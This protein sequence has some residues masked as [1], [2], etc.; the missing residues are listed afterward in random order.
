MDYK[1][2]IKY[3][4]DNLPM[5][6]RVGP[7]ALKN[8]LDNTLAL[9]KS[10]GF[11]HSQY[12][13]IHVA[14]T[15]GKGSVSHLLAA[16]LQSA[17]YKT[18]LF[19]S[20]HLKNFR[21]RIRVNGEM[22]PEEDVVKFVEEF[23]GKNRTLNLQTSFFELTA[24]MAFDYF[25]TRKVDVAVIE[26][27]LGGRL[28]STNIISPVLSIITNI[29]FD[30]TAIL[31][32]TLEKIAI[33]KAGIIKDNIPVIIGETQA[34]TAA[35]FTEKAREKNSPILFADKIYKI[36]QQAHGT[37]FS[38]SS[39]DTE[40]V[41]V[42]LGLKGIYQQK[43]L[44]TVL[45]SVDIL[46]KIGF[47]IDKQEVNFGLKNVVSLTGLQG[48]WQ[49]LGENP[50]IISDTGHNEAGIRLVVDQLLK[51]PFDRLHI[52][53]GMVNDKDVNTILSLLP[54]NAE[55]YFTKASIERALDEN[56]L[57]TKATSYGLRGNAYPSV[58][59]AL[60]A[61]KLNAGKNDLIFVGGSTFVVAEVV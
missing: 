35:I 38:F 3:L 19:T 6:H 36:H 22:I 23:I 8:N 15:N 26:V 11:P 42:D 10:F 61:A 25:R 12:K 46:R 45:S 51:E 33:E 58:Q 7:A 40:P 18:G 47:K 54:E 16:I 4:Y 49:Q 60:D 29:S 52:V 34:E 55:Y 27:G 17:G 59:K 1:E 43:N 5:F 41:K 57:M 37:Y 32:N 14:G 39:S 50:L 56:I 9:D 53:F 21:E 28:D 2:T 48:R 31:G 13:T 30:H 20:P 44:A 24:C